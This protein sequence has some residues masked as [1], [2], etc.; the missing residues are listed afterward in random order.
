MV[1][2]QVR[3]L[4]GNFSVTSSVGLIESVGRERFDEFPNL[5]RLGARELAVV[6]KA[7]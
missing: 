1:S 4:I 6:H 3:S 2:L 5:L 7:R